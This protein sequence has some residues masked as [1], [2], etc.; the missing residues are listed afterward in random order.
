MKTDIH[1][2][3][4]APRLALKERLRGI[5]KW[6]IIIMFINNRVIQP[7]GCDFNKHLLP[8]Y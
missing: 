8:T 2:K 7:M 6:S 5:R 3:D 4:F 1:N